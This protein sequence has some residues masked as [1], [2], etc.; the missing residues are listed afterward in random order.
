MFLK[1]TVASHA[2]AMNSNQRGTFQPRISFSIC[3]SYLG[4][5][6]ERLLY[7]LQWR[8][9]AK[10]VMFPY[11]HRV[12]TQ[13]CCRCESAADLSH[14]SFDVPSRPLCRSAPH[15]IQLRGSER[16]GKHGLLGATSPRTPAFMRVKRGVSTARETWI[17]QLPHTGLQNNVICL[18]TDTTGQRRMY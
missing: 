13:K 15:R 9:S 1:N 12:S 14:F 18:H 8:R 16:W 3:L 6:W 7:E 2:Q 10:R 17:T 11:R 4:L 5:Q